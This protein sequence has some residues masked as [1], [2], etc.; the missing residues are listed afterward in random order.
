MAAE[1]TRAFD[2]R[3]RRRQNEEAEEEAA[4]RELIM[5]VP[6]VQAKGKRKLF[7]HEV[8]IE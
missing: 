7:S 2:R 6:P 3:A 8:V 4:A 1:K 5:V